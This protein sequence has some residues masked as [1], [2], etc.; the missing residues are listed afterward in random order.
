MKKKTNLTPL[1]DVECEVFANWCR[2]NNLLF[3]HIAN[4][5]PVGHQEGKVW[6]PHFATI[7]RLKAIGFCSGFPDFVIKI[8]AGLL[9]IEMKRQQGGTTS[10]TQK[11][12]LK[13]LQEV[14]GIE[15]KVCYGAE[16]AIAFVQSYL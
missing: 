2:W 13:A 16:M 7:N 12:W 10:A 8:P 15:T 5:I 6:K 3:T 1:E 11:I 14:D 4:E 9:V